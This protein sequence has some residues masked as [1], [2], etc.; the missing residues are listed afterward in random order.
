MWLNLDTLE[1]HY[2]TNINTNLKFRLWKHDMPCVLEK[3]I[4]AEVSGHIA[5]R[6]SVINVFHSANLILY[7]VTRIYPKARISIDCYQYFFSK[8]LALFSLPAFP[9]SE[10]VQKQ[11]LRKNKE[12]QDER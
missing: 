4:M 10:K 11:K 8:N 12:E 9:A 3:V 5:E 1:K 6:I 2:V 7:K